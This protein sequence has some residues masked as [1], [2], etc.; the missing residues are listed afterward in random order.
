MTWQ[1]LPHIPEP[2]GFSSAVVFDNSLVVI[3]GR[4]RRHAVE[5]V[6]ALSL[7][8]IK[9]EPSTVD[10]ENVI[11]RA[12]NPLRP[13]DMIIVNAPSDGYLKIYSASGRLVAKLQIQQ[14]NNRI[15]I[16]RLNLPS[17]IYIYRFRKV[18]G[19]WLFLR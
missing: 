11:V 1:E 12:P 4:W 18:S 15:P 7:N 2:R 14:G 13:S 9:E 19:K 8:S 16:G 17:G 5:N 10:P 6:Y 3:G